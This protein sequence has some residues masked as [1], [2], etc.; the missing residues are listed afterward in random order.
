LSNPNPDDPLHSSA[1]NMMKNDL[2]TFDSRAKQW[3]ELYASWDQE[4]LF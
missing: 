3:V 4:G 1:A 2:P